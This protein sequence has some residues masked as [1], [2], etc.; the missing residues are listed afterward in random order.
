[1]LILSNANCTAP[2]CNEW[3]EEIEIFTDVYQVA[4][5]EEKGRSYMTIFV[6]IFI[7]LFLIIFCCIIWF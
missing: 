5:E 3:K 1:M 4:E 2:K 7:P 6:I